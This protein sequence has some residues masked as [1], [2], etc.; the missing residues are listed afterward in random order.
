MLPTIPFTEVEAEAHRFDLSKKAD[1]EQLELALG[2]P[3]AGHHHS[4]HGL[5]SI[6]ADSSHKKRE[7]TTQVLFG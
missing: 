7:L 4:T 3:H 6:R 5:F 1:E 2:C